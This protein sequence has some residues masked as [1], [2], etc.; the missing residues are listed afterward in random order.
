MK[1]AALCAKLNC[2]FT[3]WDA[4]WPAENIHQCISVFASF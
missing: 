4:K 3:C 1:V 2:K